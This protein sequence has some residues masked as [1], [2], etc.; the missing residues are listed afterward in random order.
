MTKLTIRQWPLPV[1]T[2]RS[3]I[4]DAALASGVPFPHGCRTGECGACKS[5]LLSGDVTMSHYDREVLSDAEKKAGFVLACRAKPLSDVHVSWL[6][7]SVSIELPIRRMNAQVTNIEQVSPIIRRIYVWPEETLQFAAGQFARLRFGNL[8]ARAYSMANTP[9]DEA[10]EFHIRLI[11]G[12]AV[13]NHI[14][15]DLKVGDT[16]QIEGPFGNAHLR[17]EDRSPLVLI[18]G[19]SG[20]APAKSIIRTALLNQPDREVHLYFGV[21]NEEHVYDETELQVLATRYKNLKVET[22][23]SEPQG[24]T[25]RRTGMLT[26]VIAQDLI[27]HTTAQFYMAGPPEMVTAVSKVV[28]DFGIGKEQIHADPFHTGG[29]SSQTEE[30]TGNITK[31][32]SGF[33]KLLPVGRLR[34]APAGGAPRSVQ[35]VHQAAQEKRAG[36]AETVTEVANDPKRPGEAEARGGDRRP[37]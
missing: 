2:G 17:P 1:E 37:G 23:L 13:S 9:G 12:G 24:Q 3:T 22:V 30:S 10:L 18:A 4:L 31:L 36:R 14:A 6:G 27:A 29:P 28:A 16:V 15:E 32:L 11:P 5:L 21:R 8:P 19:S 35:A 34:H 26:D 7:G 20:L 25:E 33:R